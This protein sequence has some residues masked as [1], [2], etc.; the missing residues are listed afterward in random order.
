M[1]TATREIRITY[2]DTAMCLLELGSLR[3]LTDPVLDGLGASFDH[4]PVHLEKNG[5][6]RATAETLGRIDAVLLSHD[7]HA[8]NLD[9][10]G[11]AL[12]ANV[13]R[14]LTTP[15]AADRLG[16]GAVGLEP[17]ATTTLTGAEGFVLNVTAMPAQHGPDN[18]QEVTG[19][20][21]GFLL[22]WEGGGCT[23]YISGD[24]VPFAGTEE[25]A[26]R[27]APVGIALLHLGRVQLAPMGKLTF[28]MDAGQA[29]AYAEALGARHVVP[30]HFEGWAHFTQPQDEARAVLGASRVADRVAWLKP[31]EAH[32]FRL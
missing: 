16:G 9:D 21:I 26:R 19:P 17:W 25:I 3:L 11:R 31:G 22:S 30:L 5:P 23:V 6:A 32:G 8:D 27:V 29:A 28:S 14:V 2:F 1:T 13:P 7:Q 12:V 10:S 20:V 4:G 18:T 15:E 24:T